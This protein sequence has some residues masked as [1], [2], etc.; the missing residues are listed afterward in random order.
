MNPLAR[1][2]ADL[3]SQGLS[4]Q[5]R[6]DGLAISPADRLTP[7]LRA[8]LLQ[9]KPDLLQ[10]LTVHGSGLLALFRDAPTWPPACGRSGPAGHVWGLVGQSVRVQDGREGVLRFARYDTRTGRVRC[11]VNFQNGWALLDPEDL[12]PVKGERRTA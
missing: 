1:L 3:D 5:A 6:G 10:L 9:F 2:L 4:L 11:R 7:E 12:S 8:Q